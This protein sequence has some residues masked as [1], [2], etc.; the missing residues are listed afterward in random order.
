MGQGS[1]ASGQPA[2]CQI[3][4][5]PFPHLAVHFSNSALELRNETKTVL[6]TCSTETSL[7]RNC[8]G[9]VVS[10]QNDEDLVHRVVRPS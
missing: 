6:D 7:H 10:F 4:A 3:L 1:Q 9:I 5:S 8:N 2:Q